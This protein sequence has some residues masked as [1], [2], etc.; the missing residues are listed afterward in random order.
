MN[1]K[2]IVPNL[3]TWTA[4]KGKNYDDLSEM[5]G[6]VISQFNRY[7]GHV[8]NNIGGVYEYYKTYDQEGP[9]YTHVDKAHQEK[10]MAFLQEEL[11]STPQWLMDNNIFS[12]TQYSGAVERIRAIQVRTLN[13]MLSLGKLARLIENEALNGQEAYSLLEMMDD[14]REGVWSELR[15]GRAIDTYRR[16]LQKAHVERLEYLLTAESQRKLPDF[17][18]YRKSTAVTTSQSDIPS[19]ARAELRRIQR[20]A[21]SAAGR[22]GDA[23]TRYHLQ[24]IVDRIDEILDPS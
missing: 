14:L 24:D 19:I 9:V 22:T 17:G 21:R 16:N 13:R 18:G 2:R 10:C 4:E 11:F 3:E 23:M 15:S 5:Y 20:S 12:K 7:M 8:A 6:Q 1:L